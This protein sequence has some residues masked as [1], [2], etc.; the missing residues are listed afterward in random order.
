MTFLQTSLRERAKGALFA[1]LFRNRFHKL[2]CLFTIQR[3]RT[4]LSAEKSRS[5]N[6]YIVIDSVPR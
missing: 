1:M 6:S 3:T 5:F 2:V 4:M